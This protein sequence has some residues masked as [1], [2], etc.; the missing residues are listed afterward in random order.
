MRIRT[1]IVGLQS[2][3]WPHAFAN[4]LNSISEAELVA[5]TSMGLDPSLISISLGKTPEEY[6][7]QYDVRLYHDPTEMIQK[8]DLDAVCI[9]AK[10][11]EIA[12]F[13]EQVAPLEVDIYIAKPMAT[14]LEAADRIVKAVR[15]NNVIAT[16]GTTE[17]FDGGIREAYQRFKS[18]A[19]GELISIRALH[20]HGNISGFPKGDWYWDEE[21]GGPELSLVW[22]AADI[23]RWFADSEVARVYAEYD[24]YLSENSPFMDNGKIILRFE[25]RVMG[26][27]DIYFS[28]NGFQFP[29]YEIELVGT[30]GAIRTQQ[31]VY[32]GTLFTSAGV[33]NFYRTQ[34]NNL[35]DEMRHWVQCCINKTEPELT[36]EDARRVIE[37][38]LAMRQSAK[39]QKPIELPK[40]I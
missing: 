37:L 21:Q 16:S 19:I 12:N 39:T 34:N 20:Q 27:I 1:G 28:V 17:R 31:S 30:T 22:Y 26:S 4:C 18:G 2:V 32:E 33:S 36:I 40:S 29:S 10:H 25:N 5:C 35:L 9:C 14:T 38:C 13:V 11:N 6:A 8:E 3:F 7:A 23:V 15:N 24:N